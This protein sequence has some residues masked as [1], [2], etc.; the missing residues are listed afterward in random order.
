VT[1]AT[2]ALAT[3]LGTTPESMARQEVGRFM[4]QPFAQ[5]HSKWFKVGRDGKEHGMGL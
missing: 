3:L 1:Y 5:L 4:A 2:S